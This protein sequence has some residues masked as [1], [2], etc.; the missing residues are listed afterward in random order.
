MYKKLREKKIDIKIE[1]WNQ[2][3]RAKRV[4]K[5]KKSKKA[6]KYNWKMEEDLL[7]QQLLPKRNL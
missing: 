2:R 7:K 6:I 4:K 5:V 3:K 1:N